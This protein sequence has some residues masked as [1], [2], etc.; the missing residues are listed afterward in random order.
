MPHYDD[1]ANR[2]ELESNQSAWGI[3]HPLH[4]VIASLALS[5]AAADCLD[6]HLFPRR[7]SYLRLKENG[8]S[9]GARTHCLKVRNLALYPDEL[10]FYENLLYPHQRLNLGEQTR[11][12]RGLKVFALRR[13]VRLVAD[14]AR[15]W[16]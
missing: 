12:S 1:V 16:T 4:I 6:W 7:R 15:W 10:H 9:G 2:R 3:S 8:R 11:T 5:W 13:I 14:L